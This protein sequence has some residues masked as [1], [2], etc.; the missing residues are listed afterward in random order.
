MRF[1]KLCLADAPVL[2]KAAAEIAAGGAK[3]KHT[4]PG[5]EMIQRLFFD[6][7]DGEAGRCAVA[8]RIE[9]ATDV[10]TDVAETSLTVPQATE[11]RTQGA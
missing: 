4:G 10:L 2:A 3:A 11:A 6:G 8:E 7:I 9:S 5:Q 1:I